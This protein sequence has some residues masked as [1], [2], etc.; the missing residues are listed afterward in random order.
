MFNFRLLLSLIALENEIYRDE[1]LSPKNENV[2]EPSVKY[3]YVFDR[4]IIHQPLFFHLIK[5]LLEPNNRRRPIHERVISFIIASLPYLK[6]SQAK[7][8]VN[9]IRLLCCNIETCA[10]VY[11]KSLDYRIKQRSVISLYRLQCFT[12]LSVC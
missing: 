5:K 8:V 6:K 2:E 10:D 1:N 12:R 4:P 9:V 7:I 11:V 3:D